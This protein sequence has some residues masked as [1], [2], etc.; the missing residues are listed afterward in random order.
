M[1]RQHVGKIKKFYERL[2]AK[3]SITAASRKM[4]EVLYS[5]I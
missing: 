4:I 2:Y 3:K 5:M 1:E